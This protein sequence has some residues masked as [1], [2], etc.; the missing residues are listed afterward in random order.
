S[1]G[2]VL[3]IACANVGGLLVVRAAGRTREIAIRMALG[4]HRG[5]LVRQ[6][7]TESLV[8]AAAGGAVGL[9][10]G[11]WALDVLLRF[12][13][14]GIPRLERVRMDGAAIAFTC[15]IAISAGGI[16]GLV[17]AF[18]IRAHRLQEALL[19]SGRGLVSG[20]HQRLRQALT[21]AEIAL[22]LMLLV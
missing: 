10:V 19:A 11:A 15:L 4:A 13:P 9:I 14:A 2:A 6:M 3:L 20:A 17:P 18:Q 21:V 8:L 1:V 12:A 22:S 16:F 7:L 5:R